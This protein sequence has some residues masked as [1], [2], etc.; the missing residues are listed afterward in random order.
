TGLRLYKPYRFELTYVRRNDGNMLSASAFA[1]MRTVET[2]IR[3]MAPFRKLCETAEPRYKHHCDPG[4]SMVNVMYPFPVSDGADARLF[5]NGSGTSASLLPVGVSLAQQEQ[6]TQAVWP[7]G[8]AN[9]KVKLVGTQNCGDRVADCAKWKDQGQCSP[10]AAHEAYMQDFCKATCGVCDTVPSEDATDAEE[11]QEIVAIRSYFAL[12]AY[13]CTAGQSGQGA[14]VAEMDAIW[15]TLVS[16][17]V[18]FLTRTNSRGGTFRV[19]FQGDG[20]SSYETFAAVAN[21]AM[22]AIMSYCFVLLYA[23][24]HT[25]SPFLALVGLFLVMLSIPATLAVFILASGSGEFSLMMCLSVF[26]VIGVGSDMLFVYTDF[27]KQS[28]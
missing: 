20:V 1:F 21:D 22:F 17:L 9:A 23:T 14:I 12:Q 28:L 26:I 25:R 2:E 16:E 10:G 13:C 3:S 6:L 8:M 11:G 19:F 15:N 24:L 7:E 5:F 18:E 27:Y 4:I